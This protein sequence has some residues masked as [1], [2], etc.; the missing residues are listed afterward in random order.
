MAQLH[1]SINPLFG[2][3]A[4]SQIFELVLTALG[5]PLAD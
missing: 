5:I 2:I 4:F 1:H 3:F